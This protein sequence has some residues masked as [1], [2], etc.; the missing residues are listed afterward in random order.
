MNGQRQHQT[1]MQ[2]LGKLVGKVGGGKPV[3]KGGERGSRLV[4]LS[5]CQLCATLSTPS[6]LAHRLSQP[7]N[8][9]HILTAASFSNGAR[10]ICK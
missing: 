1:Q 10:L 7:H 2:A 3:V 6:L 8:N 9:R 5:R 4:N